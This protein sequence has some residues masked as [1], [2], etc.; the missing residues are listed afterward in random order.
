MLVCA[1]LFWAGNFTIAKFAY[2]QNIPPNTLSF[3]RWCLVWIILFPF[4]YQEIFKLKYKIK[5]NLSLF[6]LSIA[7]MSFVFGQIPITDTI[8]VRY[9]P[10]DWRSRVLSAKFLLNLCIGASVLPFT[11]YLLKIG[12]DLKMIFTLAS[13][14]AIG[15]LVSSVILPSQGKELNPNI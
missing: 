6:F 5:E 11:S 13:F 2:L 9:V 3:L 15:V 14:I 8:L 7:A 1:T 4:T 12:Y 10:D